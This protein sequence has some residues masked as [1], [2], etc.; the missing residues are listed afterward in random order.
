MASGA[1]KNMWLRRQ[2]RPC[3]DWKSY[4]TYEGDAEETSMASQMV[5]TESLWSQAMYYGNFARKNGFSI[6]KEKSR[7]STQLGV[8]KR[9]FA[10]YR[11][12]FAPVRKK[13][14]GEHHRDRKSVRC[15]CDAKMYLSKEVIDGISQWF[16]VQFSNVHNHEPLE[17]DQARLLPAYRKI[18]ETDQER[19]LL[20]SK[21]GFP[22][23]SIVK[24]LELEKGIQGGKLP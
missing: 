9:D 16:V 12:G 5:K 3:G 18:H 11:S 7:L 23:R 10:C 21:A 15:G 17:D 19:I 20:L 14:S 22:I 8:Y 2:Q 4:V 24:V 13:L 1:S 6:R